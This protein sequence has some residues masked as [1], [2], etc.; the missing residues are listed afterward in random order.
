MRKTGLISIVVLLL[1]AFT[2]FGQGPGRAEERGR[3]GGGWGPANNQLEAIIQEPF[4]GFVEE[5]NIGYGQPYPS[6]TVNQD[7]VRQV[8]MLG[9]NNYLDS[10]G[11]TVN[12]GDSVQGNAFKDPS[13]FGILVAVSISINGGQPF[14][15]RD[16]ET[17]QPLWTGRGR[18]AENSSPGRGQNGR[19]PF[20]RGTKG[21]GEC[22]GLGPGVTEADVVNFEGAVTN[23]D[24]LGS[25]PSSF[26]VADQTISTG[27]YWFWQEQS[28]DLQAG[29]SVT[30]KGFFCPNANSPH[31]VPISISKSGQVLTLRDE[32]GRPLWQRGRRR[33]QGTGRDIRAQLCSRESYL[34]P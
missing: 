26:T 13:N 6:I 22:D 15:L 25:Y 20:G 10:I 33:G 28:F 4:L 16:A 19:G 30:I 9:P 24:N 31:L 34:E 14:L 2:L 17:G 1:G 12:E 5:I 11:L 21:P 7:N 27:P 32:T 29:E 3:A 8:V 23:I 18:S